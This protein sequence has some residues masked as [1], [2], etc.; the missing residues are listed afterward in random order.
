MDDSKR[1]LVSAMMNDSP[2][3]WRGAFIALISSTAAASVT[4]LGGWIT[5]GAKVIGPEQVDERAKYVFA[6]NDQYARDRVLIFDKMAEIPAIKSTVNQL[7]L[8]QTEL[9]VKI[10]A[11]LNHLDS[12]SIPHRSHGNAKPLPR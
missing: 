7:L 5:L 1:S 11:V 6:Q 9:G 8:Q 2:E 10:D 4:L 3:F 12:D